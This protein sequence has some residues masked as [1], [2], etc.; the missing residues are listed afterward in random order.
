[1]QGLERLM[2][3]YPK[4]QKKKY[5]KF[6][7]MVYLRY[8]KAAPWLCFY[9]FISSTIQ[10]LF[11]QQI[12]AVGR[13]TSVLQPCLVLIGIKEAFK[14]CLLWAWQCILVPVHHSQK[15]LRTVVTY[16]FL[17]IKLG[18]FRVCLLVDSWILHPSQILAPLNIVME[19]P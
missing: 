13:T 12:T 9:W 3:I 8:L 6:I 15:G 2:N 16:S 17:L 7:F 1:M 4:I 10:L 11:V 14:C 19:I 18:H 5:N